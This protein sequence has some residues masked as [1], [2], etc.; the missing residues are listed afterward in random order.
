MPSLENRSTDEVKASVA[1]LPAFDPIFG[2]IS[3]KNV[4]YLTEN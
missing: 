1:R 2:G 4:G 3:L